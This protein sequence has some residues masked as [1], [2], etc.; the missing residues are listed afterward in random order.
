M[1]TLGR[2]GNRSWSLDTPHV[3]PLVCHFGLLRPRRGSSA[4]AA[5]MA[6]GSLSNTLCPSRWRRLLQHRAGECREV[7]EG[8]EGSLL[9]ARFPPAWGARAVALPTVA[10]HTG[11]HPSDDGPGRHV[12]SDDGAHPHHG[13]VPH[14][15]AIRHTRVGTYP[16]IRAQG[17][18]LGRHGLL[19][20][21]AV[22]GEAM[23]EGVQGGAGGDAGA[24]ADADAARAAVQAD[25]GVEAHAGPE[26]D[27]AMDEGVRG[28]AAPGADD[29]GAA[30]LGEDAGLRGDETALGDFDGLQ[31]TQEVLHLALPGVS[32]RAVAGLE[33][34]IEPRH[35]REPELVLLTAERVQVH[36]PCLP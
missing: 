32:P 13:V 17:D 3:P 7:N 36:G 34:E 33:G 10:E 28:D 11:G 25:A 23:V 24:L 21:G 26:D 14:G 12:A 2:L 35:P 8:G 29:D 20:H 6:A 18:A 9:V 27:G 22:R 31:L 19:S 1:S 16:H 15:D 5:H 4:R 30:G